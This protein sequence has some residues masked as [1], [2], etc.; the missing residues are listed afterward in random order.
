MLQTRVMGSLSFL[1]IVCRSFHLGF[2]LSEGVAHHIFVSS[3]G[4]LCLSSGVHQSWLTER[5]K[6]GKA[7]FQ[8]AFSMEKTG[9]VLR[10]FYV[11]LALTKVPLLIFLSPQRFPSGKLSVKDPRWGHTAVLT[12]EVDAVSVCSRMFFPKVS[13]ARLAPWG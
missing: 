1:K 6:S 8:M 13:P 4:L 11:I 10:L 5:L 7:S 2:K 3:N 12:E 9:N